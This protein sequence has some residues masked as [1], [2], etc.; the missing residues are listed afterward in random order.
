MAESRL[1]RCYVSEDTESEVCGRES[2]QRKVCR[3]LV[4]GIGKM[5]VELL[6]SMLSCE[7][8]LVYSGLLP[9]ALCRNAYLR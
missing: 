4:V 8:E 9:F 6:A 2:S 5:K 1:L 3:R 7:V